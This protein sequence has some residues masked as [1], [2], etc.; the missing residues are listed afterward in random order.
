MAPGM[1]VE[2]NEM[3]GV[4]MNHGTYLARRM[5]SGITARSWRRAGKRMI[6]SKTKSL[7]HAWPWSNP[8]RWLSPV[9]GD[10]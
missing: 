4:G 3:E 7:R 8:S 5:I 10:L 9:V 1:S 2:R 6:A